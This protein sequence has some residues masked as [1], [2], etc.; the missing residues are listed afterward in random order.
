MPGDEG[1]E[2]LD[3]EGARTRKQDRKEEVGLDRVAVAT[4]E[5][6]LLGVGANRVANLAA[7]SIGLADEECHR[8]G[9]AAGG[10]HLGVDRRCEGGHFVCWLVVVGLSVF[11]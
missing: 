8:L 7:G 1:V 4:V 2:I 11:G 5:I 9:E 10:V 6:V 3:V